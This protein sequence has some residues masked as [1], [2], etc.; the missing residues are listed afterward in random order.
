MAFQRDKKPSSRNPRGQERSSPFAPRPARAAG[1]GDSLAPASEEQIENGA[2]NEDKLEAFGL[3]LKEKSGTITPVER[4]RM[5]VLQAKMDDFWERRMERA[6]LQPNLLQVPIRRARPDGV[7]EA[8]VP[9]RVL[10]RPGIGA[11][12]RASL[13]VPAI[14]FGVLAT[15]PAPIQRAPQPIPEV[16]G[17]YI[18]SRGGG[19]LRWEGGNSFTEMDNDI[20][21]L[22]HPGS[23][24]YEMAEDTFWDPA[25]GGDAFVR[26]STAV[27]L[28]ES[29]D[30]HYFYY[31]GGRYVPLTAL[32]NFLRGVWGLRATHG[33]LGGV[34]PSKAALGA[35]YTAVY[36]GGA[37]K[38]MPVDQSQLLIDICNWVI[39]RNGRPQD[40][41]NVLGELT[42]NMKVPSMVL[43]SPGMYADQ[44]IEAASRM[45]SKNYFFIQVNGGV[46]MNHRIVINALP[47]SVL[48]V[49]Q[50]VYGIVSNHQYATCVNQFKFAGPRSART[51]RDAVIIYCNKNDAAYGNLVGAIQGA[52]LAA[53]VAAGIPALMVPLAAGIGAG[54]QPKSEQTGRLTFG[55]KR[56]SLA[57]IALRH[58]PGSWEDFVRTAAVFFGTGGLDVLS[59]DREHGGPTDPRIIQ[60]LNQYRQIFYS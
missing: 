31:S 25:T 21:L 26:K 49:A 60:K 17:F 4:A 42:H 5:G 30:N 22:Y 46:A 48:H 7:A 10:G 9:P 19:V 56:V 1:R 53:H 54:D 55:Q 45:V 23:D 50:T 47:A 57:V 27:P 12:S 18:D 32:E 33:L 58:S 2:F 43:S 13:A 6:R 52:G 14:E 51:E 35:I 29:M 59:P 28:Y 34:A 38:P 20:T 16:D 39:A 44:T 40:E 36:S 15:G 8:G 3:R 24:Q 11:G 41:A 37:A